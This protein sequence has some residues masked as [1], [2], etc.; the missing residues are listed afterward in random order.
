MPLPTRCEDGNPMLKMVEYVELLLS[1]PNLFPFIE[2]E[3][4]RKTQLS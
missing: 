4:Q 1:R 2:A 3:A